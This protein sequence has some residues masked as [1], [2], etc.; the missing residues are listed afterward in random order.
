MGTMHM[1]IEN[2]Y[3]YTL[4]IANFLIPLVDYYHTLHCSLQLSSAHRSAFLGVT[5][6]ADKGLLSGKIIPCLFNWS[7]ALKHML[8]HKPDLFNW[9]ITPCKTL[10]L[11]GCMVSQQ[12]ALRLSVVCAKEQQRVQTPLQTKVWM[13][14]PGFAR[15]NWKSRYFIWTPYLNFKK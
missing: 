11:G 5:K 7:L 3:I 8:A 10:L 6:K 4:Y 13:Y 2:T 15:T 9:L 14:G 1:Y 12:F